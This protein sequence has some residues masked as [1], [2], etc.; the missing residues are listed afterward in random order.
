MKNQDLYEYTLM[1]AHMTK[2]FTVDELRSASLVPPF[3]WTKGVPLLRVAH[4]SKSGQ[5]THS[6]HFPE[7]ME[8]TTTVLYDLETD[9]GQ[10]TPIHAPE[11]QARLR[12]ALFR[13]MAENDAPAE[14]VRRMEESIG[15][16]A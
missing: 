8:D 5:K 1:P 3:A 7:A 11:V 2:L 14:V 6:Y 4:R 9:P 13:I 16:P 15:A 12:D 10:E